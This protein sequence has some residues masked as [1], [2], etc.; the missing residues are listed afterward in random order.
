MTVIYLLNPP[1]SER[2][3]IQILRLAAFNLGAAREIAMQSTPVVQR[4]IVYAVGID[5]IEY[6]QAVVLGATLVVS[7]KSEDLDAT[8]EA[9]AAIAARPQSLMVGIDV[10]DLLS[11]VGAA[12]GCPG[13]GEAVVL[14]GSIES[15]LNSYWSQLKTPRQAGLL[16]QLAS[17]TKSTSDD[18]E[19]LAQAAL[20]WQ[21]LGQVLYTQKNA[22][23]RTSVVL[24]AFGQERDASISE[25]S[26]GLET[27]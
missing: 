25:T 8:C 10:S 3:A 16:V 6:D 7:C 11:A 15:A 2:P 24:I 23:L 4:W 22:A 27:S 19:I 14:D 1:P 5:T 9:L 12:D 13:F 17:S 26:R 18:L 20:R 21:G